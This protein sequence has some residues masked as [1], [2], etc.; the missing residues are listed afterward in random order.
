MP[1]G[2]FCLVCGGGEG[3]FLGE[4]AYKPGF[5]GRL[6]CPS[7]RFGGRVFPSGHISGG[8]L[9]VLYAPGAPKQAAA[10][11]CGVSLCVKCGPRGI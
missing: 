1:L 11:V 3:A 4:G 5:W 2:P 6:I 9:M 7:A 10:G 8:V